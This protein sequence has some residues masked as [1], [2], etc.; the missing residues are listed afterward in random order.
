MKRFLDMAWRFARNHEFAQDIGFR[1]C[2]L[3]ILKRTIET[4]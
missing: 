2:A 4:L 1:H 3:V